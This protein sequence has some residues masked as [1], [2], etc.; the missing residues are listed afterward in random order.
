MLVKDIVETLAD[1]PPPQPT[2]PAVN[3]LVAVG[4]QQEYLARNNLLPP[5]GHPGALDALQVID[6]FPSVVPLVDPSQGCARRLQHFLHWE[7]A[8]VLLP[9]FSTCVRQGL[10]Q[11]C[12]AA[13]SWSRGQHFDSRRRLHS[14]QR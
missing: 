3:L 5:A 7:S 6:L 8:S 9:G 11:S 12:H 10:L 1:Y 2:C 4:K 13:L 14:R